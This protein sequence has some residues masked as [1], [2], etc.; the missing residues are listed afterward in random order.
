MEFC[1]DNLTDKLN[2]CTNLFSSAMLYIVQLHFV[3]IDLWLQDGHNGKC[4]LSYC[5]IN[6]S[7]RLWRIHL[8]DMCVSIF[9]NHAS[10]FHL[11]RFRQPK[12]TRRW[13]HLCKR[14]SLC[15]R[16][17]LGVEHLVQKQLY[18]TFSLSCL[19]SR[20]EGEHT[21]FSYGLCWLWLC[22]FFHP[23]LS[24]SIYWEL[25]NIRS[26]TFHFPLFTQ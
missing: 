4:Q 3:V 9:Q 21:T 14:S 12:Y 26:C 22:D 19:T 17:G 16:L 5:L 2:R 15:S 7:T 6:T 20:H 23:L 18:C 24:I 25:E 10:S 11:E 1:H 13:N 8:I